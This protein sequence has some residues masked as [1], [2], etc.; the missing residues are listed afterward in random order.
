MHLPCPPSARSSEE[1]RRPSKPMVGGS[2][3]PG[4]IAFGRAVSGSNR[5]IADFWTEPAT[6]AAPLLAGLDLGTE[7]KGGHMDV[8]ARPAAAHETGDCFHLGGVLSGMPG[9]PTGSRIA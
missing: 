5:D 4:R 8:A 9:Q 7:V 6:P 3:P 1:E 2:N